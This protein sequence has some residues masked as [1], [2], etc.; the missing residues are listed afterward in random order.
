VLSTFALSAS[1][2][3]R[4]ARELMAAAGT[5][6]AIDAMVVLLAGRGDRILTSDPGDLRRLA[7]S[8]KQ[9]PVIVGC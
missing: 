9:S 5:T 3:G 8:A 1:R 2:T 7:S 4:E 6:D